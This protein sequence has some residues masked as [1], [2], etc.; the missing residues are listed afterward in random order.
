[1]HIFPAT[2]PISRTFTAIESWMLLTIL[3][4][5]YRLSREY[6]PANTLRTQCRFSLLLGIQVY[7]WISRLPSNHT[8]FL[9][10]PR[11]PFILTIMHGI[12]IIC[13]SHELWHYSSL[14]LSNRESSNSIPYRK[15][16]WTSYKTQ[17]ANKFIVF[18]SCINATHFPA[19]CIAPSYR[20]PF[21]KG[22]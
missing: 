7:N 3:Y 22:A 8:H 13:F 18:S 10:F 1:V 5:Y 17:N 20:A 4:R 16:R 21:G 19:G 14:G 15:H 11:S 6:Q 9:P 12:F 2:S